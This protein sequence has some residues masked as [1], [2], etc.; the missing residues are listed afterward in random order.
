VRINLLLTLL[1]SIV[2]PGT[3]FAWPILPNVDLKLHNHPDGNA[4]LPLYG[5]RLDGLLGD[6]TE[7]FTF[8]F[9][10]PRS[11]M[12]RYWD[13]TLDT[14]LISGT[15]WGGEDIG[16]S[17]AGDG[18]EWTVDFHRGAGPTG[19]GWLNHSGVGLFEHVY[20]CDWL[21]TVGD[22][23]PEPNAALLFAVGSVV[24]AA[25]LRRPRA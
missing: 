21:F 18:E 22:P 25:R 11:E 14:I 23:V 3:A 17:Y 16:S 10:D 12:R 24:C 8:D 20:S 13:D 15:V 1:L 19:Y 4:A 2:L 9:D 7:E 6:K 5:L